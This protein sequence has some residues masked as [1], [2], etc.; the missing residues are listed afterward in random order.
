MQLF[1]SNNINGD[2]II[3]DRVESNHCVNVL[4]HGSGD[5]INVVD[6]RGNLFEAEIIKF[7]KRDCIARIRNKIP[8]FDKF[9]GGTL[10]FSVVLCVEI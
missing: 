8:N 5:T 10:F 2:M 4:R 7:N 3:L 1:F 9:G 6:G